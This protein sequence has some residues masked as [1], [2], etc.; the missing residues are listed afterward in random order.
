MSRTRKIV[1][2]WMAAVL[3]AATVAVLTASW[4]VGKTAPRV[5]SSVN[6]IPARE[7][8]MVL[9]A[10]KYSGGRPYPVLAGRLQAAAELYHA[11]KVRT[12]VVSG[13]TRPEEFYDEI[14]AMTQWLMEL[15]VPEDAIVGD[16]KGVR[17]LDSVLRMRDVFGYDDF[18]TI[19]Q[20]DH[21]ERALYLAD[22]HG[23]SMIGFEAG[24]GEMY[25][26]ERLFDALYGPLSCVKAVIDIAI[27]RKAKYP[28][29]R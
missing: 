15:G 5:Y 17:T 7:V 12:L 8:G 16:G 3:I 13:A 14:A 23:I 28:T 2:F 25:P 29:E 27:G 11:D 6:D 26:H 4:L 1:L 9:G 19:S 21:C 24:I 20:R 10:P 22:H 18:I